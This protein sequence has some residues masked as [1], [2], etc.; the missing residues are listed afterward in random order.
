MEEEAAKNLKNKLK[1][2]AKEWGTFFGIAIAIAI[3]I[4]C[5]FTYL[6]YFASRSHYIIVSDS[7]DPQIKVGDI[8]VVNKT[9]QVENLQIDDIIAFYANLDLVGED[10]VVVH[11]IADIYQDNTGAYKFRTKR[12]NNN[13][14][15]NWDTWTLTEADIIGTLDFKIMYIGKFLLF[16]DSSFGKAVIITDIILIYLI[17]DI[18]ND[19]KKEKKRITW[20]QGKRILRKAEKNMKLNKQPIG[21]SIIGQTLETAISSI[22]TYNKEELVHSKRVSKICELIAIEMGLPAEEVEMV[23]IAGLFHDVGKIEIDDKILNKPS[24]LDATEYAIIQKHST[25]GYE[26]LNSVESFSQIAKIILEHHERWDGNG[27]PN[28]MHGDNISL[29][30]R[31]VA[32]ADAYDAMISERPYKK[33]GNK[34]EA[35]NEIKR[36]AGSQFDPN[37]VHVFASRVFQN[38]LKE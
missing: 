8:A 34:Q 24:K 2:I 32:V 27:Y 31:I 33:A 4:Y 7:M 1:P 9:F 19:I 6:P 5:V 30:A 22:Y 10:E 18:A 16:A 17:F 20:R 3:A 13:P 12:L 29:H 26:L 11:Y 14:N 25:L 23:K 38:A 36:C 37:I 28:K 15:N 35:V 21:A